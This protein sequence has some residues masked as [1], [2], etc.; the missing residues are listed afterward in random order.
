[1]NAKRAVAVARAESRQNFYEDLDT[2]EGQ[3][4]VFG[5][6]RQRDRATKDLVHI[7]QIKDEQG[8]ILCNEQDV[9]QRWKSYFETLLNVENPRQIVEYGQPNEVVVEDTRVQEVKEAIGRMKNGKE[10][11]SNVQP[12][13]R[14][15]I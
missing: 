9:K 10:R 1:M 12:D 14:K 11:M 8:R 3:R 13:W 2:K 6:A 5:I 4:K 7:R 15:L